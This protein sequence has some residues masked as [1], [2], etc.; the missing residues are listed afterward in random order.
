MSREPHEFNGMGD[1]L[2]LLIEI[3]SPDCLWGIALR[4]EKHFTTTQLEESS[5]FTRVGA[6]LPRSL[7]GDSAPRRALLHLHKVDGLDCAKRIETTI[8][9]VE[10][11]VRGLVDH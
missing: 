8:D 4:P 10:R 7:Q 2:P 6:R 1:S 3:P 11:E 9:F 5:A